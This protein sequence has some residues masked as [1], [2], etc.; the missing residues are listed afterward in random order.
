MSM[1]K[2]LGK[3]WPPLFILGSFAFVVRYFY[4]QS[5]KLN[6]SFH[7]SFYFVSLAA[8]LQLVYWLVSVR[9]WQKTIELIVM[10][11][12][13][14]MQGFNH[15]ALATLGKYFPGKIWGMVARVSSMQ[16][17]GISSQHSVQATLNE[18]YLLL[19]ASAI[20]SATLFFAISP[21]VIAF[22]LC[23]CAI[24]T[25]FV[26]GPLQ[27]IVIEI[28]DWL[29]TKFRRQELQY[30]APLKP[31]QL[32]ALLAGYVVV[33]LVI[34]LMFSSVYY[35]LFPNRPIVTFVMR[36][37]LANTI[38]VTLGFFAFFSPGG[39][40]VREA[41]TSSFL[42]SQLSIEDALLVSV[43]F[44]LWIVVSELLSGIALLIPHKMIIEMGRE[45]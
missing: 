15:L 11:K 27:K 41:V 23:L 24:L 6:V 17:Q 7:I 43:V 21:S 36:L 2:I 31:R 38:G 12:I 8:L 18:Q 22:S 33:W 20:V 28:L 5:Y 25:V 37:V 1:L 44:R 45:Q 9:C 14:F 34:G 19:H 4:I 3:I 32:I 10:H 42:V 29:L 13:S 30:V 16:K 40:G 26:I 39:L 35:M